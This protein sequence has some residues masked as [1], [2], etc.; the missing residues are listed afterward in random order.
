MSA[1]VTTRG[2]DNARSCCNPAETILTAAHVKANG[3]RL[4]WAYDIPGDARGME[5]VPLLA[6]G[7][8]TSDGQVHDV[9]ILATM[10]AQLRAI[11][12]E[13]GEDLWE[14]TEGLPIANSK[15]IDGWDLSD[16]WGYL[17]TGVLDLAHGVHVGCC[18][19]S[20]DG[21]TETNTAVFHVIRRALSDGG[22]VGAPISLEGVTY[23]PGH[24]LPVQRFASAA[25]KQ[26]GSLLLLNGVVYVPFGSISETAKSGRG[27]IIAIDL[28]TWSVKAAFCTTARGYGGGLWNAGAGLAADAQGRIHAMTSNGT[29]DAITDWAESFLCLDDS[30][31]VVDWWTPWTDDGRCALDPSGDEYDTPVPTNVRAHN[32]AAGGGWDDMDLGS[33]GATVIDSLGLVVGAGKDSILFA[34]KLAG[35]GQTKPADLEP[36]PNAAN[37]GK[38]AFPPIFFGLFPGYQVTPTPANISD[39][40][41]WWNGKTH[42]VHGNV[43]H[44]RSDAHGDQLFG[45]A[46]NGVLRAWGLT[47]TSVT[48]LAT[49][50]EVASVESTL[51]TKGGMPGGLI[52]AA[53]HGTAGGIIVD[54]IPLGDGNMQ[55][56][57]GRMLIYDATDFSNGTIK[58]LWNSLDWGIEFLFNKFGSAVISGGRIYYSTYDGRVLCFG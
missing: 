23:D 31:K 50:A 36:G 53:T 26:R 22:L 24:G 47:S 15:T 39:L 2:Y 58:L 3:V 19:V 25:R 42:H 4:L 20:P 45:H 46:E 11:D 44:L 40:N 9:L 48:Y 30:L 8:T 5:A 37:Y 34:P 21:G 29:F 57:Q 16:H 56:T 13:T 38:L 6:P 33:G 49:A 55:L 27:W 35:M 10:A 54:V 17:S 14:Q 32:T 28:A 51:A 1:P 41:V 43:A 12:A 18:W 52:S 7:I